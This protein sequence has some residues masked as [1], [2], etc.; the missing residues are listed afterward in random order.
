MFSVWRFSI[1]FLLLVPVLLSPT[2]LIA[3]EVAEHSGFRAAVN[4][5]TLTEVGNHVDVLAD[6]SLEGREAGTEGGRKAGQYLSDAMEDYGVDPAGENGNYYQPFGAGYRNL[7]GIIRGRDPELK[8]EIIL[9]GAHYDH[10]GYGTSRNSLGPIGRIHNGADDNASG[11]AGVLEVMEAF[12]LLAEPPRRSVLFALWDG[13]EKGLLGS[14]HFVN[15]PTVPL[16]DIAFVFN[17]D[18]IGRLRAHRLKVFGARTAGGLRRLVCDAN[19]ACDMRLNFVWDVQPNS[20]HYPFFQHDV[21][22]LMFHTGLH[23]HYHRPSDDAELINDKGL[24]TVSELLFRVAYQLSESPHTLSFREQSRRE[25][26]QTRS[27]FEQAESPRPVRLG[28]SWSRK[29]S[30]AGL[31]LTKIKPGSPADQAGLRVGDRLVKFDDQK[32]KD[33]EQFRLLVLAADARTEVVVRRDGEP[34]RLTRPVVL[35]GKAMRTGISWEPDQAD[36]SVVIIKRVVPGSAAD[37]AGLSVA[38]RVYA[39]DGKGFAD[40]KAFGELVSQRPEPLRMK[41]EREGRIDQIT[42]PSVLHC[43]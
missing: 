13:E 31:R 33:G 42:V 4:S 28:V 37:Q 6:D 2:S 8:H 16:D 19:T 3:V 7:L 35:R 27:K 10:V 43:Q 24:E 25:S 23:D 30:G 1:R 36:P 26:N 15:C 18:M 22:F 5:I 20:D 32:I 41:V 29:R 9:V 39:V 11:T 21:P 17:C 14:K 38:D 34:E 12:S 40:G